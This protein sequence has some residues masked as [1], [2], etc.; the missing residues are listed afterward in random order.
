MDSGLFGF[1]FCLLLLIQFC[2]LVIFAEKGVFDT[3]YKSSSPSCVLVSQRRDLNLASAQL[4][5]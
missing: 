5:E 4:L 2:M 3:I 1:V